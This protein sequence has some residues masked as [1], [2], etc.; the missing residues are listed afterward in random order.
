MRHL[1]PRSILFTLAAICIFG[2]G[3][4]STS[5]DGELGYIPPMLG[6][7]IDPGHGGQPEE[8]A[9]RSGTKFASISKTEQRG[10]KEECYGAIT[11][12][13][14]MEKTANLEVTRKVGALLEQQGIPT[15]TTRP[16]D[17]FM[18]LDER[19]ARIQDSRYRDWILVSIH[20]N[21][22]CAKQRASNIKAKYKHPEGFEIYILP[23]PGGRS[24]EGR[25][26]PSCYN[27]VNRT[28]RANRALAEQIEDEMSA[29][30][31]I[32]NRKTKLAWFV[33]LR[34][35]PMPC[36]LIEGGFMSNPGEGKKIATSEY[37]W[38]IARAI[39]NGILKYR[40]RHSTTAS[41]AAGTTGS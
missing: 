13:G 18:T 12:S 3:C 1:F 11:A 8:A 19:I 20:F 36:V 25:R 32:V 4:V 5:R 29:I 26:V 28:G 33:I 41:S 21:R 40:E 31:G 17:R 38:K 34:E 23:P 10:L 35:S 6:V 37:Q 24:S 15:A 22:S 2:A 30:P 39:V 16:G 9:A 27:T 7:L 14:Y